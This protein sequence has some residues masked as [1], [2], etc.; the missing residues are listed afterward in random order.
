MND[1]SP[2][3]W[4]AFCTY[5][6]RLARRRAPTRA[7]AV[8]DVRVAWRSVRDTLTVAGLRIRRAWYEG[9]AEARSRRR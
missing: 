7:E 4:L 5:R 1:Q 3:A 9:R 8:E 6:R 2:Q